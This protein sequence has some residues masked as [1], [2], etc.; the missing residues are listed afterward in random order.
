MKQPKLMQ[1][2]LAILI[3]DM[4]VYLGIKGEMGRIT[5]YLMQQDVPLRYTKCGHT[6]QMHTYWHI[7]FV[8][9]KI[10]LGPI[11][12]DVKIFKIWSN[13]QMVFAIPFDSQE[14]FNVPGIFKSFKVFQIFNI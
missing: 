3:P 13:T 9:V 6:T 4:Q 10:L 11:S 12:R 2:K 7:S 1:I 5:N 14:S 8:I